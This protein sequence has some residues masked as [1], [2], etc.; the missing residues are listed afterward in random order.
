MYSVIFIYILILSILLYMPK[1]L[2]CANCRKAFLGGTYTIVKH[3]EKCIR[4][5]PPKGILSI[6]KVTVEPVKK[7]NYYSQT[8]DALTAKDT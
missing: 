1:I 7:P 2:Q 6:Q 4:D 3:F 5:R 8:P